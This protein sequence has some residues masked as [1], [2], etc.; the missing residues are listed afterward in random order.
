MARLISNCANPKTESTYSL[1]RK[2][3]PRDTLC[4]HTPHETDVGTEN[5][6]PSK[7]SKYSNGRGEVT[8]DRKGVTG[9]DQ[10]GETHETS[11]EC[12]CDVWDTS[13]STSGEDLAVSGA[14]TGLKGL[15]MPWE[16]FRPWPYRT[17]FGWRCT[18]QSW[19]QRW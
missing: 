10:V 19:R 15:D 11:S 2:S 12:E 16:R 17:E 4:L 8:K 9:S 7:T 1:V 18:G 6:D 14:L 5:G 3:V 13:G